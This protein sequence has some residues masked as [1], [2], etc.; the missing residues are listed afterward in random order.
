MQCKIKM[1]LTDEML[2]YY[3]CIPNSCPHGNMDCRREVEGA[4]EM[5]CPEYRGVSVTRSGLVVSCAAEIEEV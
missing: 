3:T 2:N 5:E 1:H 4:V